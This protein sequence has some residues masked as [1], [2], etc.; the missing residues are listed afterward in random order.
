M[1]DLLLEIKGTAEKLKLDRDGFEP[2]EIGEF[3]R[4]Y[5]EIVRRGFAD[6]S[7]TPPKEKK[8]G[9]V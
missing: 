4:R 2:E 3:E 7:F 8:R 9:R 6:S 5:D 1:A